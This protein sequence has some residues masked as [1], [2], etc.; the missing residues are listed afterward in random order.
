MSNNEEIKA[1]ES[2][3]NIVL[4]RDWENHPV[5]KAIFKELD[6]QIQKL[7][8]EVIDMNYSYPNFLSW[9]KQHIISATTIKCLREFKDM[10]FIVPQNKE[11]GDD[12]SDEE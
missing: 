9:E 2:K 4:F 11:V 12:N 5:T 1:P 3:I 6:E 10:S 8:E 7:I